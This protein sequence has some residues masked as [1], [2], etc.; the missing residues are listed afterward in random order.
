MSSGVTLITL[1]SL[2]MV[3]HFNPMGINS[4]DIFSPPMGGTSSLFVLAINGGSFRMTFFSL[5][6]GVASKD[7]LFPSHRF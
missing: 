5:Q 1:F 3:G 4:S 7:F 2:P 6:W